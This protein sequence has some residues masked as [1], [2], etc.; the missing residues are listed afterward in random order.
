MC[1]VQ[2]KN[3]TKTGGFVAKSWKILQI[4]IFKKHFME[5]IYGI[6]F[7]PLGQTQKKIQGHKIN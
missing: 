2:L 6:E 3:D 1:Q 5:P 4:L 7:S